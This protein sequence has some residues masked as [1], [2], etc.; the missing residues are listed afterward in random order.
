MLSG[1]SDKDVAAFGDEVDM[2]QPGEETMFAAFVPGKPVTRA[3]SEETAFNTRMG[4]YKAVEADYLFT[5]EMYEQG[6]ADALGS[7][8]YRPVTIVAEGQ[9]IQTDGT[10]APTAT[11][12]TTPLYWPGNAK[13][14]GFKATAIGADVSGTGAT[15]GTTAIQTDQTTEEKLLQQDLLE[16]YGFE[17]LWDTAGNAQVDNETALNYHTSKEW[18]QAN[19]QTLGLAPGGV[20]A[21]TFYKK[22]PL[23]MQHQRSKITIRLKAGE[24]VDRTSLLYDNA[25]KNVE[26]F[27]YS[28]GESGDQAIN[29]FVQKTTVDYSEADYGETASG[30]ETV[31]YSAIVQPCDYLTEAAATTKPIARINLSSQHFTFYA[32]NDYLYNTSLVAD[33]D[34]G[35]G[36]G[37]TS[38]AVRDAAVEHMRGY[39]VQPGEHLVIT[40][41]LSRDSRKIVITAYVEDWDETITTSIV[42]DYG[43][44]GDP[45]QINSRQQLYDFLRGPKNKAG[46]VAII[47]PNSLNL[48]KNGDADLAWDYATTHPDSVQLWCTLNLA[49]ATL[50]TDHPILSKINPLGNV[51][52]GTISVGTKAN[53]ATTVT[54]ALAATN[55]GTIQHV[56]V[57]P[58]DANGNKSQGKASVAGLVETNHGSILDCSSELPVYGTTGLVGGIAAHS[59]YSADN[60][61]IMPV[62]D[63]CSVN[64][65]VDGATG[66]QGA[67]IVGEAVG[68]V[69]NNTFVYG[70]TLLQKINDFKNTIHHK[71]SGTETL[72]ASGNAWPTTAASNGTG[73]TGNANTAD[74]MY[75]AVIDSQEE[76]T[77][78]LTNTY[79]VN[80][81]Y[82][83]LSD[84]FS[85]T[86]WTYA[87]EAAANVENETS[88]SKVYFK[89]DGNNMTITTDGMIFFDIQNDITDLTVKLSKDLISTKTVTTTTGEGEDKVTTTTITGGDA[90]AALA[91]SVSNGATI[92]N[93]QVKTGDHRIQAEGPGGVVV[94]AC[95][96]AKI[97]DCQF[98][99]NIQVWTSGIGQYDKIMCG[100]IVAHAAQATI[101]RCVFHSTDGTLYHNTAATYNATPV[102][103]TGTPHTGIF[104]GAILGGTA[105]KGTVNP[106]YPSVLITDCTSWFS[107]SSNA[108][109]GSVVGYAVYPDATNSDTNGITSGCQ[110]N[111]WPVGSD[112]V[113][114]WLEGLTE[115]QLIG[116]KNAVTPT[117]NGDY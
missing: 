64:A 49:G 14:Y 96:G 91:Y 7:A 73:I 16:G 45:I 77:A 115:E 10:L 93:I 99:G 106:E 26:T 46:N 25:V 81:A 20:D 90:M 47:V 102:V 27:I 8:T 75:D 11:P 87:E 109:K 43:Q 17:P 48:E 55:L 66:V 62:I 69:T 80:T 110:G 95:G 42:D 41:T 39:V 32:S 88:G 18:Y 101:T 37:Q 52:N 30:V 19:R 24:G 71:A 114:T 13:R 116:K 22:I 107:T 23:Y 68:R 103:A 112:A 5:V 60:G 51:V 12:A 70:R 105:P 56:N 76:L 31:Q 54:T 35:D 74:V 72:R 98:K 1:C 15:L 86:N 40:A 4:K 82:Y 28:Y 29:S 44:A 94:W 9:A 53:T 79:N 3:T 117:P 84:S 85:L 67:G 2:F 104:F 58:R 63:G 111:W 108:Q 97:E 113:G 33:G 34:V 65:R 89:L 92:R 78:L 61:S 50:R 21:T 59:V 38:Q 57:V 6:E 36:E 83:R 100:G